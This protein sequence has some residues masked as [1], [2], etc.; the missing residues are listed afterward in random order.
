MVSF[1]I[2][3][4]KSFRELDAPSKTP[5]VSRGRELYA[6]NCASCHGVTGLGGD[7]GPPVW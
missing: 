3:C 4:L 6:E 2:R 7:D 1:P 5:S